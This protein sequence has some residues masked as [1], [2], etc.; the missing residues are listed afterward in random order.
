MKSPMA[1]RP[2]WVESAVV[3]HHWGFLEEGVAGDYAG[4]PVDVSAFNRE[5]QSHQFDL[6]ACFGQRFDVLNRQI[7]DT[8]S[9]LGIGDHEALFR[10]PDQRLPG[11]RLAPLE[12]RRQLQKPE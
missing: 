12:L 6:N 5:L 4:L 11:Y 2:L 9:A 10:Q 3:T 8:K 7:A 1:L